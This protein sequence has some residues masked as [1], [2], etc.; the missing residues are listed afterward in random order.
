MA[1]NP[2]SSFPTKT[3]AP[4]AEYPYG[5]AR[6][7]TTPGDGTGTPWR[8]EIVNDI[9]GFQQALLDAA[10][11]VPLGQPD[12]V[13][14]SQYLESARIALGAVAKSIA[15][16]QALTPSV[17]GQEAFLSSGGRSG[18]FIWTLGDFTSEVAADTLQGVYIASNVV[19][20]ST[21]CWL[22]RLEGYVTP[23][24]FGAIPDDEA[25]N[26]KDS[27]QAAIDIGANKVV[28]NKG[29]L[30][31]DGGIQVIG[32]KHFQLVSHGGVLNI[33]GGEISIQRPINVS[34]LG[35]VV[36]GTS[37]ARPQSGLPDR[38]YSNNFLDIVIG[39][40]N[41]GDQKGV[42]VE[43]CTFD[44]NRYRL[45]AINT[46]K[47]WSMNPVKRCIIK[48]NHFRAYSDNTEEQNCGGFRFR[49]SGSGFKDMQHTVAG[50]V[51]IVDDLV[52]SDIGFEVW[53]GNCN[54]SDNFVI[55]P[56]KN[57]GYSGLVAGTGA[58]SRYNGNFVYGYGAGLE[59][60]DTGLVGCQSING[61]V[62]L[63]CSY[64][65]TLSTSGQEKTIVATGNVTLFDDAHTPQ[66]GY[67]AAYRSKSQNAIFSGNIAIHYDSDNPTRAH[68]DAGYYLA[69]GVLFNTDD[70]HEQ[71]SDNYLE[72]F[73]YGV[74][75]SGFSE[76]ITV[77][78]NTFNGCKYPI[79][80][81]GAR[82]D[83]LFS[84]NI[85][86]N[87]YS[88]RI[89]KSITASCNKFYR[90]ADYT[91]ASGRSLDNAPWVQSTLTEN[92]F[93]TGFGNLFDKVNKFCSVPDS[94]FPESGV[95]AGRPNLELYDGMVIRLS[96]TY[97]VQEVKDDAALVSQEVIGRVGR[98][99]G[100]NNV[101]LI[102]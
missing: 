73:E 38:A 21:G 91:F 42:T 92:T 60:G 54:V 69:T 57:G 26:N 29:T 84:N 13:G 27:I 16:L 19:A 45:G 41:Q 58:Y 35:L 39:D 47:S 66:D 93:I 55:A 24:M 98:S 9:F 70:E 15:E 18:D 43:G 101:Q 10:G 5:S 11:I 79:G 50:N 37:V 40:E 77:S 86:R 97:T 36:N 64:G 32:K 7:I 4:S 48:N 1:I 61:N 44:V 87:F 23:E 22:R 100:G 14:A 63:G 49:P 34:L 28:F 78:G 12:R 20:A 102:T 99:I 3:A 71:V 90:D 62:F 46:E 72:G 52:R 68:D 25:V 85:V 56:R 53:V 33:Y 67:I 31:C 8:A 65:I 82:V 81:S 96:D 51:L 59:I 30:H 80:E 83:W 17:A 75:C 6:N 94:Y 74:R 2:N 76:S 88:C 95:G 89:N